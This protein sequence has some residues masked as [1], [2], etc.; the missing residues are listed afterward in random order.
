MAGPTPHIKPD[1]PEPVVTESEPEIVNRKTR[2]VKVAEQLIAGKYVLVGDQYRTGL[3]LLK[4][5]KDR[6]F[7]SQKEEAFQSY[8]D[9]K[10]VYHHASNRLLAAVKENHLALKKSPEIGWLDR[11]YPDLNEFYLSF[12]QIQGLNSSWQWY[13]NGIEFPVLD[14]KIHPWYGTYFPT[15]FDHLIL[16]D[17]WLEKYTGSRDQALDIGTGCGVLAFQMLKHGFG[18]IHA[19]DINPNAILSIN[20]EASQQNALDRI[21]AHHSDLF[22]NIDTKADLI[23]FN[24]PWLP[25]QKEITGLDHAIYYDED[26][27][28]RFFRKAQNYLNEDGKLV[29]FFSNMGETTGTASRHPY[30]DELANHSRYRKIRVLKRKVKAP[31][32]KTKRRHNRKQEYVELWELE[33]K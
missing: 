12:P 29:L 10:S 27:F 22:E 28:E 6:I 24:P 33:L 14:F 1:R 25:A 19:T 30:D 13:I 2:P 20:E 7:G 26:L 32:R 11:L 8:R 15:R 21:T 31:S 5:L 9:K 4:A 3:A 23:V 17:K 16:F 18:H